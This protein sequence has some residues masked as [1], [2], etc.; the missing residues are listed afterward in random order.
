[1]KS[2][3][4]PTRIAIAAQHANS[5]QPTGVEHY[6][7][8]LICAL[9]RIDR[10]SKYTLYLRTPPQPWMLEL[11]ANFGFKIV[12]MPVAWT[13]LGLSREFLRAMPDALLVPSYSMPLIRPRNSVVTIHDLA[14]AIF[15]DTHRLKQKLWLRSTHAFAS[16]AARRLIAVSEQTRRDMIAHYPAA[17][18]KTSV[19]YHGYSDESEQTKL[20]HAEEQ[21][22]LAEEQKRIDDLPRPYILY[23]GTLQPRKNVGRLLDAFLA[24][25]MRYEIP[26][27]LVIAG[28]C[29][30]GYQ[31]LLKRISGM[32]EVSY[33]GY[34]RDRFALLR[35]ASLL[36]HPAIYEGFGLTPLDAFACGVPVVC[37]NTSSLPEVVGD[38][39][40][41]FDP[42]S[43]GSIATALGNVLT[44]EARAAELSQRGRE[45][46]RRFSWDDCARQTLD[47][48]GIRAGQDRASLREP[49]V[50]NFAIPS[51]A[52]S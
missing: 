38:A 7:Q 5:A 50:E 24:A 51:I 32:S 52:A 45:R 20:R 27:R 8:Q 26:H 34:V 39:A 16:R 31:E 46:L 35:S 43:V 30:W 12:P 29:G 11:P 6:C 42:Y 10:Y 25:K 40:E 36:A 3:G 4:S 47:V 23:L 21:T 28:R 44:S 14:W 41:L 22:A 19:I 48:L 37:A 49:S 17:A 9:A 18:N 13:Q 1:M 15:P 2:N 33:F